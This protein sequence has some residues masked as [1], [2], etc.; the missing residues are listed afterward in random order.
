M[1]ELKHSVE[2]RLTYT[3]VFFFRTQLIYLADMVECMY[4]AYNAGII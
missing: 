3:D 4:I 2:R 1:N